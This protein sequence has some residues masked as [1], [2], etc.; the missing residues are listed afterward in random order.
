M[1]ARYHMV[2]AEHLIYRQTSY[3]TRRV[4]PE[5]H[6]Q[7]SLFDVG[8]Y[9]DGSAGITELEEKPLVR[10]LMLNP[11]ARGLM[12][13]VL[14]LPPDAT[15]RCE[16]VEPFYA[17]GERDIDLIL[18]PRLS[19]QLAIALD[20]KRVKV[21]GLNAERDHVNKL[22]DV[23]SGVDQANKLY[24]GRNAFFQTYLCI[25][26]EAEAFDADENVPNRGVRYYTKPARGDT[27]RTTF[28]Q[29]VEFPGR[30]KLHSEIGIVHFE[31]AQPSRLSIDA[32]ANI[33]AHVYRRA[34]SRD[35]PASVTKRVMEIM[36]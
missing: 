32:R 36:Q 23:A 27:G 35:Q 11:S 18:C 22:R 7:A 4:L 20:C 6:R 21:K 1:T 9:L 3:D 13:E 31:I 5:R 24:K 29:I 19:P 28:R 17:P 34:T 14:R 10:W 26:T 16:V 8:P 12:L 33:R 30:D 15:Y 2:M 25:I